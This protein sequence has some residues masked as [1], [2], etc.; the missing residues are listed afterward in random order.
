MRVL[1]KEWIDK[2]E[3]DFH[4]ASREARVRKMPNY[5]QVKWRS[6]KRPARPFVLSGLF[7]TLFGGSWNCNR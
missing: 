2:A 1:T 3:G 7:G 6:E 5:I 4:T